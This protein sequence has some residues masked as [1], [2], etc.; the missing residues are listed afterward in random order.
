MSGSCLHRSWEISSAPVGGIAT[1]RVGKGN[2]TPAIHADEK[3]D[4]P[5]V[6]KKPSNKAEAAE[7]A[8]GRGTAKGNTG[9]TTAGRTPSRET[10][11]TDLER[12]RETAKRDRRLKFTALLHHITPR[13]LVESFYDLN[14]TAAV[15]VDGVTW[16][17]YETHLHER[18]HELHR[19]RPTGS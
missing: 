19:K 2:H 15:G 3:S 18:V 7:T 9:E 17:A 16:Q 11:L 4:A 12:V 5:I 10:A 13:L 1:G 14:R 6:P 8:E